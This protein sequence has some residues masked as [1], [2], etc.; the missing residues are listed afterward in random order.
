PVA[1]DAV[2]HAGVS[3]RVQRGG[4]LG[5]T[6]AGTFTGGPLTMSAPPPV[7]FRYRNHRDEDSIRR[8]RPGAFRYGETDWHPGP[9][10]LLDAFDVDKGAERTFAVA[11]ILEWFG[12][13]DTTPKDPN[14]GR[15]CI[16]CGAI[17]ECTCPVIPWN[18]LVRDA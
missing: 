14:E 3:G 2:R 18:V 15:R 7:A 8:V 5:L 1:R 9:Q 10:W 11:G 6:Q 12:L 4:G 17:E 16:G 13:P